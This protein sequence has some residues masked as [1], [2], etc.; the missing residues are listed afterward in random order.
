MAR[1]PQEEGA[2]K[3]RQAV[4]ELLKAELRCT[5]FEEHE[6]LDQVFVI[7]RN[8]YIFIERAQCPVFFIS[9]YLSAFNMKSTDLAVNL[10]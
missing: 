9:H 8:H 6:G 10:K 2:G 1:D 4:R 7:E 3:S 5:D